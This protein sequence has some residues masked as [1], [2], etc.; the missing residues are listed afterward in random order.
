MADGLK[1]AN[2]KAPTRTF[3]NFHRPKLSKIFAFQ[4]EHG[5]S[6]GKNFPSQ[7]WLKMRGL[8][9]QDEAAARLGA[10]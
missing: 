3:T 6:S 8:K 5:K 2:F 7:H 1:M 4:V 9:A 10:T